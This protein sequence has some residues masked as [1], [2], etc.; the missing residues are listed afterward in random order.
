MHPLACEAPLVL[1]E[2]HWLCAILH[3][4]VIH[5]PH[6]KCVTATSDLASA[7]ST[8]WIWPRSEPFTTGFA[9]SR[10]LVH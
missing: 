7:Q 8:Y 1:N 9:C 4:A 5:F 3:V 10:P 2:Q 6:A